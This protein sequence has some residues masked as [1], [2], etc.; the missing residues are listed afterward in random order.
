MLFSSA[1]TSSHTSGHE[2]G[3]SSD[4]SQQSQMPSLK[5]ERVRVSFGCA[6]HWC[7]KASPDEAG[8]PAQP[9]SEDPE[10]ASVPGSSFPS[11]GQSQYPSF[12]AEGG[13]SRSLLESPHP[14]AHRVLA[15]AGRKPQVRTKRQA[16][17]MLDDRSKASVGGQDEC[18]SGRG[19]DNYGQW[20]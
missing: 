7:V 4:P 14:K 1:R 13:I 16:I 2:P 5:R 3:C 9:P 8:M 15:V 10:H 20:A 6:W 17:S 18:R 12:T 19:Q 11:R